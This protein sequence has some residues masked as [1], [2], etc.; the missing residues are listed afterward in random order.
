MRL[1][2]TIPGKMAGNV[3]LRIRLSSEV[4]ARLGRLAERTGLAKSDLAG[5]AVAD[6]VD[7]ELE[8]IDAIERGLEHAKAGRVVPHEQAMREIRRTIEQVAK[9]KR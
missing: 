1:R 9:T 2:L 3:T 8:T 6:F 5:D 4:D 7:R